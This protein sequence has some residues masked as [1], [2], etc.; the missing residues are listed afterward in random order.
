[1]PRVI[2]VLPSIPYFGAAL[3]SLTSYIQ[4]SLLY[5]NLY[6]GEQEDLC[7]SLAQLLAD[8]A[9]K[10][11]KIDEFWLVG[12]TK[13]LKPYL[14]RA[15]N[16]KREDNRRF[17]HT[18]I[19][20]E[21][22]GDNHFAAS[23][24][25]SVI[26]LTYRYLDWMLLKSLKCSEGR[27]YFFSFL[28]SKGMKNLYH[29]CN[30]ILDLADQFRSKNFY[31]IRDMHT[32]YWSMNYDERLCFIREFQNYYKDTQVVSHAMAVVADYSIT[33]LVPHNLIDAAA[34]AA[35]RTAPLLLL[36]PLSTE[37]SF[38]IGSLMDK[39]DE[40]IDVLNQMHTK[41]N[42]GSTE[43]NN[44]QDSAKTSESEL[45]ASND[46][47]ST[48]IPNITINHLKLASN[49]QRK[50]IKKEIQYLEEKLQNTVS[51]T[52]EVLYESLVT[53]AIRS[54][55]SQINPKFLAVF[56]Q[57]PSIP[58]E[59]IKESNTIISNN[60]Y[61]SNNNLK[62][63]ISLSTSNYYSPYKNNKFWGLCYAIGHISSINLYETNLT[64]NISFFAPRK[65]IKD[66]IRVILCSNPTRDLYFSKKEA[67]DIADLFEG[68][69]VKIGEDLIKLDISVNGKS[70]QPKIEHLTIDKEAAKL[71]TKDNLITAFRHGYDIVHYSGHAFFDNVLPGRSGLLLNDNV[72]TA[73]DVRFM[74]NLNRHPIIYANACSAGRIKNISSRFTGLASAFIRAGAAGYISSLWSIDDEEA[75]AIAVTYYYTLLKENYPIGQ[76]LQLAKKAQAET[77]ST[78]TW[79][80]LVLYGDP[81]LTIVYSSDKL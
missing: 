47:I 76:C 46:S 3:T 44:V 23:Q 80:P 22:E 78:I 34:F 4:G 64:S 40:Q 37:T 10:D 36:Q 9:F 69:E 29:F 19:L 32:F 12:P 71:P 41:E 38:Y 70:I 25:A 18:T 33:D 74:L 68:K 17:E 13:K 20:R 62:Q 55:I 81:T 16:Q 73:S 24:Q 5:T 61:S 35:R 59:L 27:E 7:K 1:M 11:P 28:V 77:K 39:I 14:E 63:Q 72:L 79:V 26:L 65:Y 31:A 49:E 52:G 42:N 48:D 53:L 57:D 43:N 56:I 15:I 6:N 8:T 51:K 45:N 54:C 21:I 2:I 67:G 66:D 75:S 60:E 30:R 50:E 58:I